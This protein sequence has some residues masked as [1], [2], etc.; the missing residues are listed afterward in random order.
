[1]DSLLNAQRLWICLINEKVFFTPTIIF[2][3]EWVVFRIEF[4]DSSTAKTCDP[5]ERGMSASRDSPG[6]FFT[7]GVQERVQQITQK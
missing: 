1:M 4:R 6:K 3:G 2:L 7:C 5:S